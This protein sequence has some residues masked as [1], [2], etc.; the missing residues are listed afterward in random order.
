MSLLSHWHQGHKSMELYRMCCKLLRTWMLTRHLWRLFRR[1]IL[2]LLWSLGNKGWLMQLNKGRLKR[3]RLN[4]LTQLLNMESISRFLNFLPS[5]NKLYNLKYNLVPLVEWLLKLCSHLSLLV[6]TGTSH[7]PELKNHLPPKDP[8]KLR[9]LLMK[10]S[11]KKLNRD[12][13]S[14][15]YM[16]ITYL[17]SLLFSTCKSSMTWNLKMSSSLILRTW[18]LFKILK[19]VQSKIDLADLITARIMLVKELV[20]RLINWIRMENQLSMQSH[21]PWLMS[22]VSRLEVLTL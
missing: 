20:L 3:K 1:Q 12:I 8:T 15:M 18:D 14:N 16:R 10:F 13:I 17:P 21:N 11:K 5:Y 2:S 9:N 22:L 7:P 6:V 19:L 4:H